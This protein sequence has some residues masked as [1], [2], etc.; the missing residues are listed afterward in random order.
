MTT[1]T[2][3]PV[4]TGSLLGWRYRYRNIPYYAFLIAWAVVT[5]FIFAWLLLS[6]FKTNVEVF[7]SP[8]DLP[9]TPLDAARANYTKAWNT[10]HMSNYFLNSV[11]VSIVSVVLVVAFSAPAAYAL[12]RVKFPGRTFVSYYFIAGMGL[13]LQLIM[14]P[15]F[16]MLAD[17]HLINTRAGLIVTYVGVSIPFTILLLTG[18]FRTLP[19][20]LEDAGAIDGCSEFAIFWRVMLP[21][22]GPGLFT[23]AIFNFI[24]IWNEYLLAML[25]INQ[26]NLRTM[27]IGVMAIRYSMQYTAD[28]SGLFAAV[29]IVIIPSF[30][31]YV[32]L[33]ERV[34]AGL[35]LGS[36]K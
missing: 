27:P 36:G 15:L 19:T 32:L 12:S 16:V 25:I 2:E 18:F 20:E 17:L 34:M 5:I 10:S 33:S 6:S 13:P 24:S 11:L 14:V 26:D 23:A 28:W 9:S 1:E 3:A 21:L 8:W 35:T 4:K 22:A 29:V 31:L 7:G 30:L